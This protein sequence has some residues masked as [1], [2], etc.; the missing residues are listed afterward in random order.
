MRD[1]NGLKWLHAFEAAARHGSFVGA[2]KELGVTPAAVGQLVKSLENW[3]GHP[4]FLRG[5]TGNER[6]T[7]I[8][9][10]DDALHHITP[11]LNSLK[12][13]LNILRHHNE[14]PVITLTLSQT[15]LTHWFMELLNTFS[16]I[17]P[18]IEFNLNVTDK[19]VN[20]ANGEADLGIRCG[21][22]NW[23]GVTKKWL[24][25][26]EAILVCSPHLLALNETINLQW[27]AVQTHIHDDT[28]YPGTSFPSWENVLATLGISNASERALHINST[29]AVILA[30]LSGRGVA[31]AQKNLVRHLIAT[32]QLVQ[33]N[34]ARRWQLEWSYYLVTPKNSV[35]RP[36][37]KRFHDWLIH[38][39][40]NEKNHPLKAHSLA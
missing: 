12:T 37:V 23:P 2:A 15:L 40:N 16:D 28:L 39:T 31:I 10:A 6:L 34:T 20:V 1:L 22:G 7:L 24:M 26:E 17:H 19:L 38:K 25:E 13:G 5:R 14:R 27:L 29:S 3:V 35:M 8:N 9:N 21:P 36:D 32:N 11:G 4:L 18:E 30:A 33:L